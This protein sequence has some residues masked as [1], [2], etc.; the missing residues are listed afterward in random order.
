MREKVIEMSEMKPHASLHLK[1]NLAKGKE[2]GE[3]LT[4]TFSG[5]LTSISEREGGF[6]IELEDIGPEMDKEAFGK[7][8]PEDRMKSMRKEIE[9]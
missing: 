9:K 1:S 2:I 6:H 4:L 7:M 8:S 3:R 5:K